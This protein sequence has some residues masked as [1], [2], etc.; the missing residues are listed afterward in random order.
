MRELNIGAVLAECRKRKGATQEEVAL[1]TGVSKASVSKWETGQSYPDITVLPVLASFFHI[2][3]DQLL[4]YRPELTEKEI[5]EA[6]RDFTEK[7]GREPFLEVVAEIRELV[8][9]YN[10]C[11]P[12]FFAMAQ[13]LFN[14]SGLA[15]SREEGL[16]ILEEAQMLCVRIQEESED[17]ILKKDAMALEGFLSI[18][19]REPRRVLE[20][21]GERLRPRISSEMLLVGAYS[22]LGEKKRAMEYCQALLYEGAVEMLDLFGN[23][24]A[25]CE[26]DKKEGCFRAV[27]AM[28]E[29]FSLRSLLPHKIINLYMMEAIC[30]GEQKN[31]EKTLAALS[32]YEETVQKHWKD[33]TIHGDEFFDFLEQWVLE[34]GI[35][36]E[37]PRNMRFIREEIIKNV[38][39]NPV[40]SFLK[41]EREFRVIVKRLESLQTEERE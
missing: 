24:L 28:E 31:R 14:N 20:L 30:Y 6:Y 37:M 3:I 9:K 4:G 8:R 2:T 40:F 13:L 38:R 7:F 35:S 39:D 33:F 15:A 27:K 17:T 11:Y 29:A 25:L 26:P 10:S 16:L 32:D 36:R 19:K 22:L 5:W 41:E 34:S 1:F 18:M 23:Y 21:F 12:L